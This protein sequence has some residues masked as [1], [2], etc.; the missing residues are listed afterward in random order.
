M[1]LEKVRAYLEQFGADTRIVLNESGTTVDLAAAA[2]HT[3]EAY[4]KI[5][6]LSRR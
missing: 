6:V 4:C 3:E 5:H 1:S 2:L